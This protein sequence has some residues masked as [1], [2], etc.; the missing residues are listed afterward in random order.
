MNAIKDADDKL[1]AFAEIHPCFSSRGGSGHGR[2][3]LPV[4]PE[5]NLDCN[6][7]DRRVGGL[8]YH[9]YRPG[10]ATRI[11]SPQEAVDTVAAH[12]EGSE[13]RVVGVAGPGEPL[14]ND[15]TF[16]TLTL[17]AERFPQLAL[18]IGTNGLLLPRSLAR[19]RELGVR[20]I[21]V[22]INA[23]DAEVAARIYGGVYYDGEARRGAEG[24]AL[25]IENQLR[26]VE[27]AAEAGLLVKLNSIL[28]P[29]VNENEL[30]QIA[31]RGR[32]LGATV[33]NI[34]PLIPLGRFATLEAPS[35]DLQRDVRSRCEQHLRQFRRCQQCRADAVGTLDE[36]R[37]L[38]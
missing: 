21:T 5:C 18:C 24:T 10:V 22:T 36:K 27:Q 26:G 30:E 13:L 38:S 16:T 9:S 31:R 17:V 1:A 15:A 19:L 32:Q 14:F 11:L 2:I 12:L 35:C 4:A 34:I 28:I 6:Y 3:H 25:L 20:A 8:T 33:Q 37:Y 7:C 29:T 23:L